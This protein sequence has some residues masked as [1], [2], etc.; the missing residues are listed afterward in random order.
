MIA[1]ITPTGA[2]PKQLQLCAKWMLNQTYKGEVIWVIV[3]DAKPTTADKYIDFDF[4]ENWAI[5]RIFPDNPTWIPGMNTQSRNLRVGMEELT[6][7][8]GID[9]IFIIED[10]DYY[11]P[12]YLEE[13][14]KKLKNHKLV[15]EQKSIYYHIR[16]AVCY[17]H[18][19]TQHSS[20]FQTAF[21]ISLSREFKESLNSGTFIDL[22]FWEKVKEN[23]NL[24]YL[25]KP[26]SIGIKGMSGRN[27]IG[28]GHTLAM[29]TQDLKITF[30]E[31]KTKLEDLIGEDYKE[32][33]N[34]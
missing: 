20:L 6:N 8:A 9:S 23:K 17:R 12:K 27:G 11:S 5:R 26:L 19:N 34:I 2:R 22:K 16:N 33:E 21:D 15:G 29:E 31:T 18:G 24:F 1:L 4:R 3:D 7:Y 28:K 32:Y 13:M 30:N 14:V 25:E 10:D